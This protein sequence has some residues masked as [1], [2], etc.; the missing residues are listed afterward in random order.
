MGHG[1]EV[2]IRGAKVGQRTI[3]TAP[4]KGQA[5]SSTQNAAALE[6]ADRLSEKAAFQIE[7]PQFARRGA[8]GGKKP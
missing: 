6:F 1:P 3:P 8:G 7:M 4:G 2:N 5:I